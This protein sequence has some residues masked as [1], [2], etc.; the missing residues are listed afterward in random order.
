MQKYNTG[1]ISHNDEPQAGQVNFTKDSIE[2][3]HRR[4]LS[5][6]MVIPEAVAQA[7]GTQS[8][9]AVTENTS[10]S[11]WCHKYTQR[12][13]EVECHD[14]KLHGAPF[15]LLVD[16][17]SAKSRRNRSLRTFRRHEHLSMKMAVAITTHL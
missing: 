15:I 8:D 3:H 1:H 6:H 4:V 9:A 7:G 16:N 13:E 5:G 17:G 12:E 2:A 10:R 11:F 14:M